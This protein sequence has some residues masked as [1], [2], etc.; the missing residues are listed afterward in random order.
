MSN[1]ELKELSFPVFLQCGHMSDRFKGDGS[2]CCSICLD[3]NPLWDKIADV[4]PFVQGRT[5]VCHVC[6]EARMPS[7]L[8]LADFRYRGEGSYLASANCVCGY[9]KELHRFGGYYP[10][11]MFS[12]S[13][14]RIEGLCINDGGS[15][16]EHGAYDEDTFYCGCGSD[17]D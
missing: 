13:P 3:D 1:D 5:A 11:D 15:W 14:R 6:N 17:Y 7:E 2:P 12:L 4:I 10:G 8:T 16:Q 9:D